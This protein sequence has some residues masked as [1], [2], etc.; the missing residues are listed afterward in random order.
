MD[1]NNIKSILQDNLD[2][3]R[4]FHSICVAEESQRLA[5]LYAEDEE[6]AYLAG[7][8]HDITKCLTKEEHLKI[9][10]DFDIILSD[11]ESS[12]EKLWHAI[13]GAAYVKNVL[14]L[15]SDEIISAIRFHT[16]AKSNMSLLEKILYLADFTSADRSYDDVDIMRKLV[17]SNL[18]DAMLYALHYTIEELLNKKAAV[19]PDTM[20]AYNEIVLKKNRGEIN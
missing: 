1:Y 9:F 13:S 7:L 11:V 15:D 14:K 17:N 8:L 6:N 18:N 19:H 12:S 3:Y 2:D 20:D 10:S 5:K 16:T 4:Y